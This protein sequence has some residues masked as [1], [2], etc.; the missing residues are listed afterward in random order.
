MLEGPFGAGE[1]LE[2]RVGEALAE[3]PNVGG[4]E[5]VDVGG[6]RTSAA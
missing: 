4:P 6:V 1:V 2:D 3:A 5:A